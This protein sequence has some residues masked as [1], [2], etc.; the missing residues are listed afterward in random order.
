MTKSFF[1][2]FSI[3]LVVYPVVGKTDMAFVPTYEIPTTNVKKHFASIYKSRPLTENEK[4]LKK[5]INVASEFKVEKFVSSDKNPANLNAHSISYAI[6]IKM[7]EH[8]KWDVNLDSQSLANISEHA[9]LLEKTFGAKSYGWAWILKQRGDKAEAKEV[10]LDLFDD[11][12]KIAMRMG[13]H[14][15]SGSSPL[16]EMQFIQMALGPMC[17]TKEKDQLSSKMQ[18]V[19]NHLSNLPSSNIQT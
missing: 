13:S 11:S 17:E 2:F 15:F 7:Q 1:W 8:P 16:S 3:F 18:K 5:L 6:V 10:L 19:K 9:G 4:S 14:D 12:V